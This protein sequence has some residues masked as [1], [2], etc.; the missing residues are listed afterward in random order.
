MAT[1]SRHKFV[2]QDFN[3]RERQLRLSRSQP[4]PLRLIWSRLLG[5]AGVNTTVSID[6]KL[7]GILGRFLRI[8]D[9]ASASPDGEDICRSLV[10]IRDEY[11]ALVVRS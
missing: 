4:L 2:Q 5:L 9:A 7:C 3:I 6:P 11:D 10:E 1:L 8:A